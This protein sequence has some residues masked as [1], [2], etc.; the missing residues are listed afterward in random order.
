M[1]LNVVQG[2]K[3]ENM[4]N[5]NSLLYIPVVGEFLCIE[6]ASNAPMEGADY[7]FMIPTELW[8]SERETLE[9]VIKFFVKKFFTK[10]NEEQ[11]QY[12]GAVSRLFANCPT[13]CK[14]DNAKKGFGIKFPN[15]PVFTPHH[16]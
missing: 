4:D 6:D 8:E 5:N 2:M 15:P 13:V 7:Y 14:E 9:E 1:E 16:F 10:S 3:E 11:R 12:L